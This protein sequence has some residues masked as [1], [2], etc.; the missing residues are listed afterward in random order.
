MLKPIKSLLEDNAIYIAIF[1]TIS[2]T[3][4]SLVKSDFIVVKS[5]TEKNKKKIPV[6]TEGMDKVIDIDEFM[7]IFK[8]Q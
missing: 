3:I 7:E 2:I 5:F 4:G 8:K 1:F 6:L